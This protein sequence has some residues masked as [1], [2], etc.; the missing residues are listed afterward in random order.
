ME[1]TPKVVDF[2]HYLL[3]FFITSCTNLNA[4]LRKAAVSLISLTYHEM[5]GRIIGLK[6]ILYMCSNISNMAEGLFRNPA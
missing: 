5:N 6:T 1:R 2:F 3:K 4:R